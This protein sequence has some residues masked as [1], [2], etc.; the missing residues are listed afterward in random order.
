MIA[1]GIIVFL[2]FIMFHVLDNYLLVQFEEGGRIV[3]MVQKKSKEFPKKEE[4]TEE[5]EF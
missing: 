1:V 2:V 3:L 5:S 4:P